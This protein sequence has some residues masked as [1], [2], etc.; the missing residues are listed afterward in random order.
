[1][2]RKF[3]ENA[4][5]SEIDRWVS[6]FISEVQRKDEQPYPQRSIHQ[7]LA[8]LQRFMLSKKPKPP[9]F[10]IANILGLEILEIFMCCTS[11]ALAQKY[12][13]QLSLQWKWMISFG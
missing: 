6:C 8:G 5:L 7:I 13:K 9:G 12:D 2:S 4:G 1:M 3:V 10:S 11:R